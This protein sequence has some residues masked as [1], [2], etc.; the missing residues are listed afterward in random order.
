MDIQDRNLVGSTLYSG[1]PLKS[2]IKTILG[3]VYITVW[4]SFEGIAEGHLLSGDPRH[5]DEGCIVDIWTEEEDYYFRN[6]NKRHLQTGTIISYSRKESVA[7]RT[8]EEFS[9]EELRLEINKKFLAFQ[10]ILNST[11]S[12][13]VLFR[14]KNLAGEMEKSEKIVK[15]IEARIAE[16]QAEEFKPMPESVVSEL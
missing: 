5:A 14:I 3:K 16:V 15:A 10:N 4:N 8:L 2:Y 7:A 6:K 13:A 12:I 1:K 9:D 11:S